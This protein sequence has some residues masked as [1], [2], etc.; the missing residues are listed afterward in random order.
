MFLFF[1]KKLGFV[2]FFAFLSVFQIQ[3][4]KFYEILF[5]F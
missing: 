1:K 2:A 4:V 3:L 5:R